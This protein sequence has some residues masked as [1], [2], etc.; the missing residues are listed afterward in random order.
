MYDKLKEQHEIKKK[1]FEDQHALKNQVRGVDEEEVDFLNEIDHVRSVREKQLR[2][3]ENKEVE[4]VKI[5]FF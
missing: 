4:E 2:M 5:S 3:E 1:E